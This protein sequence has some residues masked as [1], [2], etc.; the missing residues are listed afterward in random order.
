MKEQCIICDNEI[1][2]TMCCSG[3]ECGCMG[4][5]TE[6]PVCSKKCYDQAFNKKPIDI[7]PQ[8]PHLVKQRP[9]SELDYN[10]QIY[11]S[12]KTITKSKSQ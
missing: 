1:E 12:C 4:L 7:N 10:G 6:P 5:P 2:I 11:A 8:A 3:R 9:H